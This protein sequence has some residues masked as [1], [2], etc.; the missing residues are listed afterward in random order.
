MSEI[1]R[2][3]N[4][5]LRIRLFF[6]MVIGLFIVTNVTMYINYKT[7]PVTVYKTEYVE[8][9]VPV[10]VPVEV[11]VQVPVYIPLADNKVSIMSV[12]NTIEEPVNDINEEESDDKEPELSNK[13]LDIFARLVLSEAGSEPYEGK[14]AVAAVVLNRVD[15][16]EF[17]D[18][19]TGVIFQKG[20]FAGVKSSLFDDEPTEDCI[21]AVKD[22]ISGE[23]PTNGALY[24]LNKKDVST[25][26]SKKFQL[27]VRIGDHWFYKP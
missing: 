10:E 9:K 20:Q 22:A 6:I 27:L 1:N 11:P 14:V 7:H 15:D 4:S 5:V 17:P 8:V 13:V 16:Q 3:N 21:Q 25:S 26:W 23:D 12:D 2:I 24:F 19:I 18:S